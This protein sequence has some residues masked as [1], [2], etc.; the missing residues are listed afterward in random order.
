LYELAVREGQAVS[1]EE[2]LRIVWGTSY[3]G[4]EHT[5]SQAVYAIRKALAEEG[6]IEAV[7]GHGYRFRV[8]G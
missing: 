8:P 5:V 1:R 3:R 7:T 2:L 4:F 6:W